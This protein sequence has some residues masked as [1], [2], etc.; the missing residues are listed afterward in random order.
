MKYEISDHK[1]KFYSM[2]I[3]SIPVDI[4]AKNI[5]DSMKKVLNIKSKPLPSED[6]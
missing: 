6:Y 4:K 3:D 5:V 2:H 1:N